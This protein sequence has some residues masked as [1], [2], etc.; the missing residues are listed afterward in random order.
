MT[1]SDFN[2]PVTKLDYW[3]KQTPNRIYLIQ[4]TA[5]GVVKYS[6]HQVHDEVARMAHYLSQFPIGSHIAILSLNCAHWLMADLA[7]QMAGHVPIPIYPTASKDTITSVLSH[8]ESKA[9]FVGKLLNAETTIQQL[10]EQIA[11]ISIYQKHPNMPY[12]QDLVE[13]HEPMSQPIAV[14]PDDLISIIYTSGTT[15]EPKGVMITYRAVNAALSLIKHIIVIE[16][17]DR[18]VS[19][20]PLAHVAERMAVAFTSVFYGA[21]VYFIHSIETFT[22]DVKAAKPT[23]FFGVP[24]IW[25]KIKQ[26]V[27]QKIGGLTVF[28]ILMATPLINRLLA[29]LLLKQ[30][31]FSEVRF[32]LCAAAA[33]DTDILLWFNRLGLKLNEAYGLSE[34][35]GLSHMVKQ[36]QQCFG[37]VGQIIPGCECKLS[38][39]GEILLRNPA[40]MVGYYKQPDLTDNT[41]DGD[42]W[43]HT[44]D[45]G[46]IDA[47]GYLALVGRSKDMFKT[48]KGK[49]IVP[50]AIELMCQ[51]ILQIDHLIVMGAGYAQPLLLVSLTETKYAT[52]PM[53]FKRICQHQLVKINQQLEPHQRLSHIF[54]CNEPWTPETGFLTPTLKIKRSQIE[55]HYLPRLNQYRND[56]LVVFI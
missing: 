17:S 54:I 2:T 1:H 33:V 44:G 23:I 56:E 6:W 30:L 39:K 14:S 34:T 40:L 3:S 32:A 4:P 46:H 38:E 37:R 22:E 5:D 16:T 21:Q 45:L 47:D 35:C 53:A 20:L 18:F 55:H 10:P 13:S 28:N 15:G 52:N 12:W 42:G 26:A 25:G 51:T 29:K 43:L 7:I 19:Y 8:S 27:E 41:I 36:E 50:S 11:K 31:G 9:L 48:T 49:Y 24:R